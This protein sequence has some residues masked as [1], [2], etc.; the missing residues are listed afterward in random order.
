M[1]QVLTTDRLSLRPYTNA[2]F[3][4]Y[5]TRMA[6]DRPLHMGGPHDRGVAVTR[7]WNSIVYRHLPKKGAAA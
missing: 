6:R 3:D 4:A 7:D 5:A 2:C 1:M